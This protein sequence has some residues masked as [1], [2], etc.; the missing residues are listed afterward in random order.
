ML[1]VV[2]TLLGEIKL[3][4]DLR[5][6]LIDSLIPAEAGLGID[7]F[8]VGYNSAALTNADIAKLSGLLDVSRLP[9]PYPQASGP[10]VVAALRVGSQVKRLVFAPAPAQ[11]ALPSEAMG[12]SGSGMAELAVG[13]GALTAMGNGGGAGGAVA[14]WDVDRTVGPAHVGRLGAGYRSGNVLLLADV[15]VGGGGVRFGTKGLGVEIPLKDPTHPMFHL[16]GLSL[17]YNRAP[18]T[19]A[20]EF[21]RQDMP[22]DY[23]FAVGGMAVIGTPAASVTALGSYAQPKTGDPSLFVFG[24]LDLSKKSVGSGMFRLEKIAAG[25]GYHSRVRTPALTEVAK[26]PFVEMLS[27]AYAQ[28]PPLDELTRLLHDGWVTPAPSEMWLAAG[29]EAL[30]YELVDINAVAIAQFGDELVAGLYGQATAQFPKR[31]TKPWAALTL[32]V[33]AEY[34][35]GTDTL[36]IDAAVADGSFVLDPACR[37]TGGAA[38]RMWFGR[39]AHPGEFVVSVGGYHPQFAV[40]SHYPRPARLGFDWRI[41]D[42]VHAWGECYAALTPHAFMAGLRAGLH[43]QWGAASIDADV[44]ADALIEWDPLYFNVAWGGSI[45][46]SLGPFSVELGAAGRVWGPPVGGHALVKLGPFRI[47]V[48]FG[49]SDPRGG[50][51]LTAAQFRDRM[52]PGGTRP[53]DAHTVTAADGKVVTVAAVQG[54]IPSAPPGQDPAAVWAFGV[55]SFACRVSSAVPLTSVNVNDVPV[56]Q[57]GKKLYIRPMQADGVDSVMT[58]TLNGPQGPVTINRPGEEGD[59]TWSAVPDMAGVPAALWAKAQT[60][61]T[62]ITDT[63]LVKDY[64]GALVLTPPPPLHTGAKLIPGDAAKHLMATINT[65][66]ATTSPKECTATAQGQRLPAMPDS[67]LAQISG[68]VSKRRTVLQDLENLDIPGFST[69]G[70]VADMFTAGASG[71]L[72]AEP[73][74]LST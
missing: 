36:E 59:C 14:W 71:Y 66:P 3:G 23:P 42:R 15:D 48:D 68:A 1:V 51:V 46:G 31:S 10:F 49:A 9:Q 63:G 4:A 17:E 25:F 32:D 37:L 47:N 19:I 61:I 73:Q 64:V 7:D 35:G 60:E 27:H 67:D 54:L 39:S 57:A 6:P 13:G 41:S 55:D 38:V 43:G 11:G 30:V 52:L 24:M 44:Y 8:T 50:G 5:I 45:R 33:R 34:R 2:W 22:P 40:P 28:K 70:L 26:F 29:L 69:T 65:A 74:L 58:I 72:D 21:V 16:D 18:L 53:T 20:G 56:R 12:A 62:E